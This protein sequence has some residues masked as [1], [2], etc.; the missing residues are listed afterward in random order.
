MNANENTNAVETIPTEI[1]LAAMDLIMDGKSP[2]DAVFF[3][4]VDVTHECEDKVFARAYG[5]AHWAEMTEEARKAWDWVFGI[6]TRVKS[7]RW[8][9]VAHAYEGKILAR[10]GY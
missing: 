10:Q 8:D 6:E 2:V 3:A 4:A 5:L 7:R 1:A 9:A